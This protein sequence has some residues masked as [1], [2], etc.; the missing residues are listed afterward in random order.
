MSFMI[1]H[2]YKDFFLFKLSVLLSK[3]YSSFF[4]S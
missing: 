3:K 2:C 1:F 4:Y